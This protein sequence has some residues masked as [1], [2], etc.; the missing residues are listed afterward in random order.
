MFTILTTMLRGIFRDIHTMV[1]NVAFPLAMLVGLGLYFDNPAYSDRLLSG[2]LTTNVLFGATM[3]TAFY[4]MSHRNRGVYKLLRATPFSTL[5]FITAMTG[6]RTVLA[7]FVSVCVIIV[8]VLLLG[9]SLSLTGSALML[10][11]LLIGTVCFTA[12]GFIAANLS[13]DESNVNMISNLMS[14]PL[15]FTSEAFY[16]LEQAPQWVRVVGQL[17]PF[18]YL[19]EAMG[20][21]VK[22]NGGSLSAIGL[23]LGILTGFT[24]V[25]LVLA[26]FTFRWDSERPASRAGKHREQHFSSV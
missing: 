5:S 16:S 24:V 1:W 22:A 4:V 18:H 6:A 8:S 14:F 11:V 9:V 25:C 7:L 15:L 12:I 19:V 23:P 26:A 10:L 20:I 2:V 21:A 17:Q 3:V 13:R